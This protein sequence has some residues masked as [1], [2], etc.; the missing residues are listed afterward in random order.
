MLA[1]KAAEIREKENNVS[2]E[3]NKLAELMTIVM[4]NYSNWK[5]QLQDLETKLSE[6]KTYVKEGKNHHVVKNYSTTQQEA[7]NKLK[8]KMEA[9]VKEWR[10]EKVKSEK[11]SPTQENPP[12]YKTPWGIIGI[13]AVIAI[14]GG[15]I[16]YFVK[17]NVNEED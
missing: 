2:S 11:N 16:Y 7:L 13:F 14:I 10:A 15:A 5:T 4:S 8:N 6:I 1:E 3:E 17:Q 9:K 12:W